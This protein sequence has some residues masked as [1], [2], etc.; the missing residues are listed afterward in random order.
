MI[1]ARIQKWLGDI[2]FPLIG[3]VFWNWD[4][5]FV[6]F[7]YAFDQI[8]KW[9]FATFHQIKRGFMAKHEYFGYSLALNIEV[10][11]LGLLLMSVDGNLSSS[12]F[13]FLKT[14]EW[15]VPQAVFLFPLMLLAE[16]FKWRLIQKGKIP[17]S[18]MFA[19]YTEFIKTSKSR[20]ALFALFILIIRFN[21]VNDTFL[22]F[23]FIGV[24]L[25]S[26]LLQTFK[27]RFFR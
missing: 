2:L 18:Q 6:L 8:I 22:P 14:E 13:S 23:G 19:E 27:E 21:L 1:Q 7:F 4:L 20:L 10:L 24:L 3:V 11:M 12:L 26:Y 9:L 17:L 15:G 5:S 25:I 16:Y